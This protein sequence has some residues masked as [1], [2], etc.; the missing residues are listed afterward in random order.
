MSPWT[1]VLLEI[2]SSPTLF[3]RPANDK[4]QCTEVRYEWPHRYAGQEYRLAVSFVVTTTDLDHVV[5]YVSTDEAVRTN[6]PVGL[7]LAPE[8]L[9]LLFNELIARVNEVL[10]RVDRSPPLFHYLCYLKCPMSKGFRK[11]VTVDDLVLWPTVIAHER[12]GKNTALTAMAIACNARPKHSALVIGDRRANEVSALLTLCDVLQYRVYEPTWPSR[13]KVGRRI[14]LE[15]PACETVAT[16]YPRYS[17]LESEQIEPDAGV[18]LGL[19][20]LAARLY[21]REA[22]LG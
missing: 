21:R 19:A 5:T 18:G 7:P 22:I 14:L 20:W 12:Y 16:L 13:T 11:Q 17:E 6:S 10:D 3:Q 15:D 4:Q 8:L 1:P 2:R 9:L